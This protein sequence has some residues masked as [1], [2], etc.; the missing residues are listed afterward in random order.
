MNQIATVNLANW[1]AAVFDKKANI[2]KVLKEILNLFA[3]IGE[4]FKWEFN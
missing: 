1:I 4:L 3:K 2:I